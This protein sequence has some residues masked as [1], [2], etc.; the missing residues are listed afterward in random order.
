MRCVPPTN[1]KLFASHQKIGCDEY[2]T[3]FSDTGSEEMRSSDKTKGSELDPA[4]HFINKPPSAYDA[5]TSLGIDYY[6][7]AVFIS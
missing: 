3:T 4:P 5:A 7:H 6:A 2:L 1:R